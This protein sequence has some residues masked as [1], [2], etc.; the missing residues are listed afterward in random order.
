MVCQGERR[1]TAAGQLW[2]TRS[3]GGWEGPRGSQVGKVAGYL[4][5]G[6]REEAGMV[7][8]PGTSSRW[9]EQGTSLGL[10][11]EFLTQFLNSV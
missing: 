3:E 8:S 2:S 9:T 11:Y 1:H 10:Q 6:F 5:P 4:D 7:P